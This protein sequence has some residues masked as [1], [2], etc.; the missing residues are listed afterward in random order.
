VV[1]SR[2]HQLPCGHPPPC[3]SDRVP[4]DHLR[5]PRRPGLSARLP[6]SPADHGFPFRVALSPRFPVTLGCAR[7]YRPRRTASPA[8]KRSSSSESVRVV[9]G[10]PHLDGRCSP[11]FL[12]LQRPCSNLG[13][14]TRPDPSIRAPVHARLEPKPDPPATS[15]REDPQPPRPGEPAPQRCPKTSP[16]PP[17]LGFAASWPRRQPSDPLRSRAAP[18]LDGV[19]FSPGLGSSSGRTL[20]PAPT[21]GASKCSAGDVLRRARPPLV[22]FGASSS[23]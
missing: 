18:P 14:S 7:L 17:A 19:S 12:P 3:W 22:G 6:G 5:F 20:S 10:E 1:P 13:A 4:P 9:R 8:S 2:G 21:F 16:S 15:D 11:G 23:D